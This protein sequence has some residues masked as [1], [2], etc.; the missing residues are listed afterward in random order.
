[1]GYAEFEEK[2]F[3]RPLYNQLEVGTPY[4]WSPGQCFEKFIGIDHSVFTLHD[5]SKRFGIKNMPPGVILSDYNLGYIW[6]ALGRKRLVPDFKL[7]LF[8][9]AK[10]PFEY[11]RGLPK[12]GYNKRC[13]KFTT[14]IPQQKMLERLDNKLSGRALVIYASPVFSTHQELFKY[15]ANSNIIE[16]TIFPLVNDLIGHQSWIYDSAYCGIGCSEPEEKSTL[17]IKQHINNFIE[18][19]NEVR[20]EKITNENSL[21]ILLYSIEESL[22]GVYD[23]RASEY[24][25][26]KEEIQRK[27]KIYKSD[28]ENYFSRNLITYILINEF[29]DIYNLEWFVLGK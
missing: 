18:R 11:K 17:D 4:V 9:Q 3:E 5:L 6:K 19:R 15:T 28:E 7:N 23:I 26:R 2:E 29:C 25:N 1:M 27:F 12:Y 13:F 14:F 8:I 22:Q 20:S 21:S 24:F 16:H 10:R